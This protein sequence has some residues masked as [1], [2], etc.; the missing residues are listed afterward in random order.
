MCCVLATKPVVGAGMIPHRCPLCEGS[1]KGP[2]VEYEF[3]GDDSTI[4]PGKY[5]SNAECRGC[6]G[7]GI[8]W[9]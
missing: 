6:E 8:V 5:T 9:G 2:S 1:G 3:R 4:P 7:R